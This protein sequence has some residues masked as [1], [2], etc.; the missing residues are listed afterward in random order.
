MNDLLE[1]LATLADKLDEIG[2][3][4]MAN[5]VDN[6]L[7]IVKGGLKGLV[8]DIDLG[9]AEE[10][11]PGIGRYY[12]E[13]SDKPETFLDLLFS[14]LRST[15]DF[16]VPAAAAGPTTKKAVYS[17]DPRDPQGQT[18]F[19]IDRA[20]SRLEGAE[21]NLLKIS[22]ITGDEIKAGEIRFEIAS[23]KKK[24]EIWLE[25]LAPRQVEASLKKV[26]VVRK[27]NGKWCVLSKK[28][29]KLGCY[30]SKKAAQ[31]RL[32]QIEF[33]KHQK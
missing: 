13:L 23:A 14:F 31:K 3:I 8:T 26:A 19:F 29:K 4:K 10:N 25:Q 11:F 27:L 1:S 15:G 20:I 2:A 22:E 17:D 21:D 28:G 9:E 32:R 16:P 12:T 18:I 33:F 30:A 6:L 7:A 5:S 24:L